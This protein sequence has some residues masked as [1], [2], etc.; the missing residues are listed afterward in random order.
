MR[1]EVIYLPEL[2]LKR[3][4][5]TQGVMWVELKDC[6]YVTLC[7]LLPFKIILKAWLG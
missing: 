1:V 5:F 4:E 2:S 6:E 3:W 7:E